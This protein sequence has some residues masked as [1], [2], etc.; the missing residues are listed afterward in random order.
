MHDSLR[1]NRVQAH[2]SSPSLFEWIFLSRG[3]VGTGDSGNG[4]QALQDLGLARVQVSA[5]A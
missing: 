1:G 2:A 3:D 4:R 5:S